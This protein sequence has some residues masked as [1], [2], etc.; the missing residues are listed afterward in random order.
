MHGLPA[1]QVTGV[2]LEGQKQALLGCSL[3][4]TEEKVAPCS[5]LQD[6]L[7]KEVELVWSYATGPYS[8]TSIYPVEW[9]WFMGL[10]ET[11][12]RV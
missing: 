2:E 9:R 12:K 8:A 10:E 5:A 6:K 4:V 11:I 3:Q 1:S 7:A